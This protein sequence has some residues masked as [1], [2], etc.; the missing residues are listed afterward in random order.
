MHPSADVVPENLLRVYIEFSA[1]MGNG[2]GVDFVKLVD[3]SGEDG[4]AE[5]V[6][7]GAFL[8][9]EANFWSP[10]HTRY[11]LFFDPGRVKDDILP[12]RTSGR[13]LRAGRKY[14]IDV[15]A[16]WTD[17][18]GQPLEAGHRHTFRVGPAVDK[19]I[20]ISDMEARTA[21][22]RHAQP[23]DRAVSVAARSRHS[24]SRT[25]R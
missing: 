11:T 9:V 19:P 24:R 1:P 10:D 2:V 4:A 3:L 20:A 8:P 6:E 7:P 14:A 13:P 18:N 12:N 25:Q 23:A 5:R 21:S 16:S 17:A 22:G 15:A